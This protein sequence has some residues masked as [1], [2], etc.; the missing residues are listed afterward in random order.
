MAEMTRGR[1]AVAAALLFLLAAAL[2]GVT[3]GERGTDYRVFGMLEGLLALLLT[4]LLL[5]RG[6]WTRTPG[7]LGWI[8]VGYGTIAS[9]QVLSL[10]IPPPGV[11]QWVSVIGFLF[12]LIAALGIGSRHRLI[13]LLAGATVLLALLKF[14]VIPFLWDRSGPG[15]GEAFG[16]GSGLERVRRMVV[17]HQPISP[18]AELLGVL[19]VALWV[20]Y[21][22]LLWPIE[23]AVSGRAGARAHELPVADLPGHDLER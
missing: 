13:G 17:E 22:R 20:L 21:T 3:P 14:S 23:S 16:L 10:V 11:V 4:Y 12:V 6:V 9:A 18:E 19:A 5:D 8:A 15:P 1:G 7:W 2:A